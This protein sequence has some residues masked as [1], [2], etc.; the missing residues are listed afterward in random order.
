[1]KRIFNKIK[2]VFITI[3][4]FFYVLPARVLAIT[5]INSVYLTTS[6]ALYGVEEPEKLS[7]AFWFMIFRF[8]IIPIAFFI[9]IITCLRK[10]K[11]NTKK[12]L[13]IFLSIMEI[14]LILWN[15]LDSI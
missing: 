5:N 2:K 14:G 6:P 3:L 11:G 4:T 10:C 12:K 9:G 13:V 8:F 7:R 15:V 1:M